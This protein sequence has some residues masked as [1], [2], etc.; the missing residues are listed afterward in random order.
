MSI[1]ASPRVI[2][3]AEDDPDDVLLF[4]R[5]ITRFFPEHQLRTVADGDQ[6]ISYLRGGGEYVNR[7]RYPLPE[8]VVLDIHLPKTNGLH[9]LEW[10]RGDTSLRGAI[11]LIL[12]GSDS[13]EHVRRAYELRVN[14]FLRKRPLLLLPQM[15]KGILE[16]WLRTNQPP[17]A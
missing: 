10:I 15:A 3:F 13:E 4:R 5:V 7:A 2:L 12:T 9:V 11:V 16:Y 6:A 14:S 1:S 17:R 8:L